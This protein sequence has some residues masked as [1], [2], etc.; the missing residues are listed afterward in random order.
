[1]KVWEVVDTRHLWHLRETVVC[2]REKDWFA[3]AF[4]LLKCIE[5]ETAYIATEAM[6]G[7]TSFQ[8]VG[9]AAFLAG[10]RNMEGRTDLADMQARLG[11]KGMGEGPRKDRRQ[12]NAADE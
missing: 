8:P 6:T 9:A 10:I 2:E 3:A 1:V 4:H 5:Q 7:A 11:Q 12:V